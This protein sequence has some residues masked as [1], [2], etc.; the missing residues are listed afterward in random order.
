MHSILLF[1]IL[2]VFFLEHQHFSKSARHYVTPT[3]TFSPARISLAGLEVLQLCNTPKVEGKEEKRST[4]GILSGP[5]S[6][7]ATSLSSSPTPREL[8]ERAIVSQRASFKLPS[9]A[10]KL[11]VIGIQPIIQPPNFSVRLLYSR[12]ENIE[13][14]VICHCEQS[15]LKWNIFWDCPPE[16]KITGRFNKCPESLS[17]SKWEK[18]SRIRT[19][20]S[21]EQRNN[22]FES[23]KLHMQMRLWMDGW[24]DRTVVCSKSSEFNE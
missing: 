22:L 24:R 2:W 23:H 4:W 7:W 10:K 11:W 6:L 20:I 21:Q 19:Y 8:C 14:A 9:F 17:A 3:F 16:K 18:T 15:E 12:L 1:G 5:A 13:P